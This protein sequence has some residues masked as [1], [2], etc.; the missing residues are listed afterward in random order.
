MADTILNVTGSPSGAKV[1][2]N[3]ELFG[4]LPLNT[5]SPPSGSVRIDVE[6]TGYESRSVTKNIPSNQTTNVEINLV[7]IGGGEEEE[8]TISILSQPDGAK[9]YIDGDREG[10]TDNRDIPVDEGEHDLLLTLDGFEDY[11]TTFTVDEDH[12]SGSIN[13]RFQSDDPEGATKFSVT[14]SPSDA[15]IYLDGRNIEDWQGD[16]PVSFDVSPGSHELSAKKDGYHTK[17]A[18][19]TAVEGE[20]TTVHIELRVDDDVEPPTEEPDEGF[21][22]RILT[23]LFSLQVLP[24]TPVGS[25]AEDA[26]QLINEPQE[27]IVET[28][29]EA[30]L[31]SGGAYLGALAAGS[32]AVGVGLS[33]ALG[34]AGLSGTSAAAALAVKGTTALAATDGMMVWLAED[35]VLS[36]A[37]F[38]L[39]KLRD[40]VSLGQADGHEI[41]RILDKVDGWL[42]KAKTLVENSSIINPFLFPFRDILLVN[43]DK[44]FEDV[45]LETKLIWDAWYKYSEQQQGGEE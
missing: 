8:F 23:A 37:G 31:V 3:G 45:R 16:S 44:A 24:G 18:N 9:I 10:T 26:S 41:R 33:R 32:G 43:V 40:A 4:F 42:D 38:T 14:S 2:L 5:H 11:E 28:L 7:P 29:I 34:I 13:W 35:N 22:N 15:G 20:T 21:L 19:F 1:Y 12:P 27:A 30:G 17:V 39:R 6:K 25:A 36:G